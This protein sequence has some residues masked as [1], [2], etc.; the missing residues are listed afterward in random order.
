MNYGMVEGGEGGIGGGLAGSQ[1]GRPA[2]TVYVDVDDR[3]AT[4][5]KAK[6]LGGEVVMPPMEVPGGLTIAQFND[7]DGNVVGILKPAAM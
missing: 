4:L 3:Q 6:S 5:D 1:D 2:L 7:P